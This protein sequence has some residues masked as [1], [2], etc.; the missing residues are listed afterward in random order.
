[1]VVTHGITFSPH[2]VRRAGE[3][4]ILA[5]YPNRSLDKE[6]CTAEAVPRLHF[7][8]ER[9][10]IIQTSEYLS[11]PTWTEEGPLQALEGD[12]ALS[13]HQKR[14][15]SACKEKIHNLSALI[16]NRHHGRQD[17]FCPIP[18][19]HPARLFNA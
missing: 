14:P 5:A 15:G 12:N 9:R 7:A 3:R 8:T 6:C 10:E 19:A 1:M 18:P 16:S 2:I 17:H 4:H 11:T 13:T